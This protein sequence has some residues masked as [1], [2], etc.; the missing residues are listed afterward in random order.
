MT[1]KTRLPKS[2]AN[3]STQKKKTN[4][5]NN[6]IYR[7]DLL[8]DLEDPEDPAAPAKTAVSSWAVMKK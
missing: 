6:I 7:E 8:W 4:N 3:S 5:K 1:K 2:C